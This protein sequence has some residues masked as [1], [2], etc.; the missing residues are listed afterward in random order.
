MFADRY[1]RW[2]SGTA[3]VP[4][5][6]QRS[7]LWPVYI[8]TVMTPEH[9]SSELNVFQ[10]AIL[11]LLQTGQRDLE[12][13]A[14]SLDLDR[15]LVAFIIAT[16]LQPNGWIDSHQRVTPRGG[17]VLSGVDAAEP[18]LVVQYAFQDAVTGQ[19]LPRLAQQLPELEPLAETSGGSPEFVVDRDSGRR[20]RPFLLSPQ[21][22][23]GPPDKAGAKLALR[24]FQRDLR[25]GRLEEDAY[26][27]DA[28]SDDF[29]FVD[30]TPIAAYVWCELFVNPSD[31]QPWLVSDPWR[32]T[33]AAVWFRKPLV[34]RL[35]QFPGLA[36]RIAELI[37]DSPEPGMAAGD[38]LGQLELRV[39]LELADLP[40]LAGQ[41]LIRDHLAR[42]LR[43]LRR[44]E[45]QDRIHQEELAS[46][47]Q[48]SMSALEAILKWMLEKWPVDASGWPEGKWSRKDLATLLQ[49]LPLKAPLSS[50]VIEALCGQDARQVRLAVLRRDRPLKALLTGGLLSTYAR[51]DH[52]LIDLPARTMQLDRLMSFIAMRNEGA[53]ASG[54]KLDPSNVLEMARFAIEWHEQFKQHY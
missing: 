24:Q 12:E 51:S 39:E 33:D 32:V 6:N 28:V 23:P 30:G 54:Q 21:V 25:R 16:Q 27:H 14:K 45:G 9:R 36:R 3:R 15:D 2:D 31:L 48:E 18:N 37:P 10:E 8:W 40:H 22:Q 13:L 26:I 41:P 7:I 50:V 47:A 4:R 49:R 35:G 34:D 20:L 11:G 53:H 5:G 29:D 17:Q 19:W 44:L 1:L 52:P 38:W 43:Q 42:V 46:L